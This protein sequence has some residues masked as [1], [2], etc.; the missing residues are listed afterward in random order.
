M[1]RVAG[2]G[3]RVLVNEL[4]IEWRGGEERVSLEQL[5]HI[6]LVAGWRTSERFHTMTAP[7]ATATTATVTWTTIDLFGLFMFGPSLLHLLTGARRQ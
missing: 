1:G 7:K 6:R 3:V 5:D 4:T 2:V